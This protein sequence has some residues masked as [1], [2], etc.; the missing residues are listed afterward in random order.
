MSDN[1]LENMEHIASQVESPAVRQWLTILV[2]EVRRLRALVPPPEKLVLPRLSLPSPTEWVTRKATDDPMVTGVSIPEK[3]HEGTDAPGAIRDNP[4][5]VKDLLGGTFI[6]ETPEP[7]TASMS[8]KWFKKHGARGVEVRYPPG[9]DK[10][11]ERSRA[12]AQVVAKALADMHETALKA[13]ADDKRRLL[14]G[15]PPVSPDDDCP[16]P[17]IVEGK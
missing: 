6:L 4:D 17:Q 11:A 16:P 2:A 7:G 12:E 15:E 13:I 9:A 8:Q 5:V 10:G 14:A 3:V 1:D